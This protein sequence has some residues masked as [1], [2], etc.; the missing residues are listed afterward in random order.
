M[1]VAY[2]LTSR[3]AVFTI[4]NQSYQSL[5]GGPARSALS[6]WA[7]RDVTVF[8]RYTILKV[9]RPQ[10]TFR[11]TPLGGV[12]L[13]AG[14]NALRVQGE[15]LPASL[16]TG[17]GTVDPY[18]GLAIGYNSD[19]WGMSADTTYRVNPVTRAGISP[20]SELRSDAQV[21]TRLFPRTLPEE[22]LPALVELSLEANYTQDGASHVDGVLAPLSASQTLK[23]DLVLEYGTLRWQLGVGGRWPLM[24]SFAAPN[25][26]R[27]RF[28]AFL[29]FEYYWAMPH[30]RHARRDL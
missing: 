6:S 5:G 9:D 13:P 12:F 8:V 20:G 17:S 7:P 24:Q 29:Y 30:R 11:I 18:V 16:Q 26:L 15:Y 10:S 4:L 2:G 27:E 1:N 14:D 28:S 22:G 23:Q 21:E 25:G 3:W 19:Q